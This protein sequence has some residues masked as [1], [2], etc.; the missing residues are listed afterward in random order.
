M[1]HELIDSS[2]CTSKLH[3]K[4]PIKHLHWLSMLVLV[5]CRDDLT[6]CGAGGTSAASPSPGRA[7]GRAVVGA[8]ACLSP[9]LSEGKARGLL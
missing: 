8:H 1:L 9:A 4:V 7:C 3:G 6:W 5:R 2:C